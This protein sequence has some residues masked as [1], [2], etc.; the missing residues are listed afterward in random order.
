MAGNKATVLV[1]LPKQTLQAIDKAAKRDRRSRNS[2]IVAILAESLK[3]EQQES[4]RGGS[5]E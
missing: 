4:A 3:R 5:P 2:Q 1:R